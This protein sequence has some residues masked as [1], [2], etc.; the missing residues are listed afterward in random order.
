M[1]QA[2]ASIWGH[3]ILNQCDVVIVNFNAGAFL[4]DAVANVLSPSVARV[5]VIDN[6]SCDA[7][8]DLIADMHDDRVTT[9]RNTANLDSRLAAISVS[10]KSA[11]K[12]S[13]C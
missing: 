6:A 9:I 12:V 2:I 1:L 7:S 10:L 3:G 8:L 4:K 11:P 5:F 13:F